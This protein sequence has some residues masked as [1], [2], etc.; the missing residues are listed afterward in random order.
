MNRLGKLLGSTTRGNI[1]EALALSDRPLTAYRVAMKYN[2]N[3]AK[4]YL[5]MKRLEGLGLVKATVRTKG[6]EYELVDSDLRRLALK[7]SSRV[8]TYETWKSKESKR[9]RFRMGLLSVPSFSLE[10]SPRG[11]EP[12]QRRLPGELESLATLGRRKF[13]SKYRRITGRDYDRV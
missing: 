1:A 12:G 3:V 11:V 6:R 2:M 8:Q 10:G 5:E 4:V 9:T 13:D 7:L